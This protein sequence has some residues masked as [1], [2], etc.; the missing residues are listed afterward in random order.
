MALNFVC[1]NLDIFSLLFQHEGGYFLPSQ[2]VSICVII[3]L[4]FFKSITLH[5]NNK[6]SNI[7]LI[8]SGWYPKCVFWMKLR[9]MS[10]LKKKSI[11]IIVLLEILNDPNGISLD[12]YVSVE[13]GNLVGILNFLGIVFGRL[14]FAIKK[15]FWFLQSREMKNFQP[16]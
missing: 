15:R 16:V 5:R 13:N 7:H 4:L 12:D 9:L 3:M 11:Q 6:K 10:S 8:V 2:T 1:S 14:G